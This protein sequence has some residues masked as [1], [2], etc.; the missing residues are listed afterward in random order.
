MYLHCS[1]KWIRWEIRAT[2]LFVLSVTLQEEGLI[3]LFCFT[4]ACFINVKGAL[5]SWSKHLLWICICLF[6][7]RVISHNI[8]YHALCICLHVKQHSNF[9][10][11]YGIGDSYEVFFECYYLAQFSGLSSLSPFYASSR[12]D[13]LLREE[14]NSQ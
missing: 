14:D 10:L 8:V 7:I 9:Q 1:C 11:L 3:R 4:L 12:Q 6:P 5:S 2:F 13:P